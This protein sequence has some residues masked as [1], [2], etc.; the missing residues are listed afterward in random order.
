[1]TRGPR[2]ATC[3]ARGPGSPRTTPAPGEGG[4]APP[5]GHLRGGVG[6]D[7]VGAGRPCRSRSA[8]GTEGALG[9][10]RRSWQRGRR[11]RRAGLRR[12][13]PRR[14]AAGGPGAP[15]IR[16]ARLVAAPLSSGPRF[17]SPAPPFPDPPH[18][19]QQQLQAVHAE[20][21]MFLVP[22]G[23]VAGRQ[24]GPLGREAAAGA[25][26]DLGAGRPRRTHGRT[27]GSTKDAGPCFPALPTRGGPWGSPPRPRPDPAPTGRPSPGRLECGHSRPA[28]RL[29]REARTARA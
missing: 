15:G 9:R 25:G 8:S 1:V 19:L 20:G 24:H 7:Q 29:T 26:L 3:A 23:D 14:A 5:A 21:Q 18:V 11:H 17:P 10:Q 27:L 16:H 6:E 4:S 28:S 13:A 22:A 12:W 2:V